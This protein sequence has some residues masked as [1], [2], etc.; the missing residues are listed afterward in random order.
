MRKYM[1][2]GFVYV[3]LGVMAYGMLPISQ[4]EGIGLTDNT[5][6]VCANIKNEIKN[7]NDLVE[8]TATGGTYVL[9]NSVAV[10]NPVV[11]PKGVELTIIPSIE[12]DGKL[13][14]TSKLDTMFF[15]SE[16]SYLQLGQEGGMELVL[17]GSLLGDKKAVITVS[18]TCEVEQANITCKNGYGIEVQESGICN[19][20]GGRISDCGLAGLYVKGRGSCLKGGT[21]A[22]CGQGVWLDTKCSGWQM[23]GG[24]I[25]QCAGYGVLCEGVGSMSG[26]EIASCPR[27]IYTTSGSFH[28]QGGMLEG[29]TEYAMEPAGGTIYWMGGD[30]MHGRC[31]TNSKGCFAIGGSPC[32]DLDSYIAVQPGTSILQVERMTKIHPETK[33]QLY[34]FSAEQPLVTAISDSIQLSDSIACYGAYAPNCSVYVQ[35]NAIYLEGLENVQNE[36]KESPNPTSTPDVP[37]VKENTPTQAPASQEPAFRKEEDYSIVTEFRPELTKVQAKGLKFQLDWDSSAIVQ[38]DEMDIYYSLDQKNYRLAKKVKGTVTHTS[39][40][41]PQSYEGDKIYF[42]LIGRVSDMDTGQQY[43]TKKSYVA[44]RYLVDKVR[45]TTGSYHTKKQKLEIKW[46]QVNNCTG[47][48]VFLKARCNGKTTIKRCATVS[49]K[50]HSVMISDYK[51]KK[52]FASK[53]KPIRIKKYMVQA[54]YQSGNKT[55]FSLRE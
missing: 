54:F 45:G 26:G 12:G 33:I 39:L 20:S 13:I 50:K 35:N 21:I 31:T 49:R 37:V 34:A 10:T 51:I 2:K 25:E 9:T 55:A 22:R 19:M 6:H 30:V 47:Y 7:Y 1:R 32:M 28:M 24:T 36:P 44:S 53:G 11:I 41:I 38:L 46:K 43:E 8:A 5:M 48:H 52:L 18:G 14:G 27:G 3:F 16:G 15:V 29:I 4:R 17:D 40:T 42:Y 23:T